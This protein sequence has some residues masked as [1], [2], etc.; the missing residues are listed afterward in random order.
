MSSNRRLGNTFERDFA[1]LLFEKGFWVHIITQNSHGQPADILAIK[2][3]QPYL[4]DCK[5]CSN[6]KFVYSRIEGNQHSAMGLW[7]SCGNGVGYFALGLSD[8]IYMLRNDRVSSGTMDRDY[9][10]NNA[11]SLTEWLSLK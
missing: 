6:D 10:I 3:A 11:E 4:I 8:D 1:R 2:N 5:V 9:I 7:E